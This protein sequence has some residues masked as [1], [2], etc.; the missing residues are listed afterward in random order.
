MTC[1]ACRDH[2]KGKRPKHFA[3]DPK[4]AFPDGGP[5]TSDNWNCMT[6]SLIRDIAEK[7]RDGVKLDYA[8]DQTSAM[9]RLDNDYAAFEDMRE[10]ALFV[11][12]Y[13]RR[14]S[15]GGM[16]LIGNED[17]GPP[18]PPTEAEALAISGHY[19][20][21]PPK[22]MTDAEVTAMVDGWDKEFDDMVK[23]GAIK[24]IEF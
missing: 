4:C 5:F 22:P 10:H 1:K 13:K 18:R 7:E 11:T 21:P 20:V 24:Y 12:W 8:G 9:I 6:A 15:T 17:D 19:K 23:S 14:G 3:S 2:Y 16:W